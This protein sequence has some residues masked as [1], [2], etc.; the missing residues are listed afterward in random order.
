MNHGWKLFGVALLISASSS[1]KAA[2]QNIDPIVA[3][4]VAAAFTSTHDFS[5]WLLVA[6]GCV[7][8]LLA[9]NRI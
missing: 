6:V 4:E 2:T 3:Q 8:V 1:L 9:R 7:G 5:P